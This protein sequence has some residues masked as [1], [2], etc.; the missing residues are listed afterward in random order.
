MGIKNPMIMVDPD[1]AEKKFDK[2]ATSTKATPDDEKEDACENVL[3]KGA[4]KV[5]GS[6]LGNKNSDNQGSAG[7]EGSDGSDKPT[8]TVTDTK[9]Q[10]NTQGNTPS[11]PSKEDTPS[12]P[13]K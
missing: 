9:M 3:V 7:A 10:D 1:E 2:I 4:L 8:S 5:L 13:S 6:K 11:T 12:K